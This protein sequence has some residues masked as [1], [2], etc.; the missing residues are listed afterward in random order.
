MDE[1][2]IPRSSEV[3]GDRA[4]TFRL[5]AAPV[6][7]H[8]RRRLCR[9]PG[10]PSP[11][12]PAGNES[13]CGVDEPRDEPRTGRYCVPKPPPPVSDTHHPWAGRNV[14]VIGVSLSAECQAPLHNRLMGWLEPEPLPK[15][16]GLSA[17]G[18]RT[19]PF[20]VENLPEA[21]RQVK[22]NRRKA[23]PSHGE[24]FRDLESGR[25]PGR[26]G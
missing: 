15:V 26:S 24:A 10:L 7:S 5:S 4:A 13:R 8:A 9:P 21:I 19:M 22:T 12:P 6:H 11:Y 2:V 23:L 16:Y 25:R 17:R 1:A 20:E 14:S 3:Q 18:V